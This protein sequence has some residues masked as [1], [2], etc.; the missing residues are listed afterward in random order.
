MLVTRHFH[1]LPPGTQGQQMSPLTAKMR[2]IPAVARSGI[3]SPCA[4]TT[5]PLLHTFP[6]TR[7]Q[8]QPLYTHSPINLPLKIC[9]MM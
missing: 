5:L 2:H 3:S 9:S 4:G 8:R 6:S 1:H 7:T